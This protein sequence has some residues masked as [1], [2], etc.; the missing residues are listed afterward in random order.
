M[1]MKNFIIKIIFALTLGKFLGI[2]CT[3]TLMALIKYSISGSFT[4]NPQDLLLNIILGHIA[5]L[6]NTS[7]IAL[8]TEF[9]GIKDINFNLYQLFFGLNKMKVD[10]VST[11]YLDNKDND[12]L[13]N[14]MDSD[15]ELNKSK[16]LDT[17]KGIDRTIYSFCDINKEG[18]KSLIRLDGEEKSLDKGKEVDTYTTTD[19]S[20]WKPRYPNG[21]D[22]ASIFKQTNP[23]P[24]F[25]VP[26]GKVP[27]LDPICEHIDYNS[28]ILSQFRSMGLETAL[29]QK[30]NY[31]VIIKV[32]EDKLAYSQD[33]LTKVPT[34]PTNVNEEKLRN[35]IL[36]DLDGYI[37]DKIRAEARV[38]LINSR[39]EFIEKK[40]KKS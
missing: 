28:H 5:W 1:I 24:G 38:T 2:F 18:G 12:R 15:N 40:L 8:F 39:L 11:S 23:G 9:L 10:T 14:C 22:P 35:T 16:P 19:T 31:L 17:G 34:R 27:I 26:G 7:F 3:I 29:K 13:Y 21:I 4:L 32:L 36:E 20:T 6:A 33:A 30:E 37:K 25:N